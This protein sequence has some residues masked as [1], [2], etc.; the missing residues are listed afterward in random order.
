[1]A[2]NRC[3][4]GEANRQALSGAHSRSLFQPPANG[5]AFTA[6]DCGASHSFAHGLAHSV[7]N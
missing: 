4:L 6:A 2:S 3:S 5:A 7:A 1:M